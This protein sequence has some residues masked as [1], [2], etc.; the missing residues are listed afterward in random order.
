MQ[1]KKIDAYLGLCKRGAM[2]CSGEFQTLNAIKN[3]KAMLVIIASD[4]SE[5]SRKKLQD[6]CRFYNVKS[7][8]Y[9][10]KVTL[11]LLIGSGE[12]TSV[13]ILDRNFAKVINSRFQEIGYEIM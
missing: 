9:S 12:K 11:G 3:Y 8:I 5:N 10:N 4:A 2:L 13:T 6:K 1:D 7:V